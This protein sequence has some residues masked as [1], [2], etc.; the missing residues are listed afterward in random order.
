MDGRRGRW[1]DEQTA[2]AQR[3]T[4]SARVEGPV[5]ACTRRFPPSRTMRCFH[6]GSADLYLALED[7]Q[8]EGLARGA[9]THPKTRSCDA[10]QE[11]TR[12]YGP[13][14]LLA[15][16]DVDGRLAIVERHRCTGRGQLS[17]VGAR[18]GGES[19]PRVVAKS[20]TPH[21]FVGRDDGLVGCAELG[22]VVHSI[23]DGPGGTGPAQ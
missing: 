16:P 2:M 15:V 7:I 22:S 18:A 4:E 5:G 1:S 10:N 6:L 21:L 11:R 17:D 9:P 12:L 14:R 8:L 20:N 13:T 19:N 23:S 3:L